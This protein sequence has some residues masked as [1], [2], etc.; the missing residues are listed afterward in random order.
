MKQLKLKGRLI[1]LA[2]LIPGF[3]SCQN[4]TPNT[5]AVSNNIESVNE[6][7]DGYPQEI[8]NLKLEKQFDDTKWSLYLYN[9]LDTVFIARDE[10]TIKLDQPMSAYELRYDTIYVAIYH[11]CPF[12]SRRTAI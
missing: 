4:K 10:T 9:C 7:I 8:K 1:L 3:M 2:S 5:T 11:C 6:Q 12:S